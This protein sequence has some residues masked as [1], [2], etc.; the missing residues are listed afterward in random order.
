M[1]LGMRSDADSEANDVALYKYYYIVQ[2]AKNTD[3]LPLNFKDR[4][5]DLCFKYFVIETIVENLNKLDI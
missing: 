4:R 3:E 5:D 1:Q 2:L